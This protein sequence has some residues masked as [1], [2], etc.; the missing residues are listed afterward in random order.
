[1][2]PDNLFWFNRARIDIHPCAPNID[3]PEEAK[4]RAKQRSVAA[5]FGSRVE[6]KVMALWAH[7][8][9]VDP[10]AAELLW[11]QSRKVAADLAGQIGT[12]RVT[13]EVLSQP[14]AQLYDQGGHLE[15][16]DRLEPLLAP[17]GKRNDLGQISAGLD[18]ANCKRF[19]ID[20]ALILAEQYYTPSFV[21]EKNEHLIPSLAIP[22]L[23]TG[24]HKVIFDG[25]V[26]P[27]SLARPGLSFRDIQVEKVPWWVLE[28]KMVCQYWRNVGV[29]TLQVA[30]QAY[31]KNLFSQF[32]RAVNWSAVNFGENRFHFPSSIKLF[33]LRGVAPSRVFEENNVKDHDFL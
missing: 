11:I 19:A 22:G 5:R 21:L 2:S 31:T 17:F 9:K 25:V 16:L 4:K 24:E 10:F 6:H 12:K 14:Y 18:D 30:P 32:G 27:K 20:A 23:A 13:S 7:Q 8:D 33:C 1:M 15:L 3:S 26:V 29:D 28:I